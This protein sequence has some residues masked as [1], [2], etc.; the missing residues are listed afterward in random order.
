MDAGKADLVVSPQAAV[1][2]AMATGDDLNVVPETFRPAAEAR[3]SRNIAMA[4][5]AQPPSAWPV[6]PGR[7]SNDHLQGQQCLE[8]VLAGPSKPASVRPRS[9]THVS[10][11]PRPSVSVDSTSSMSSLGYKPGP[12]KHEYVQEDLEPGRPPRHLRTH[13]PLAASAFFDT[14]RFRGRMHGSTNSHETFDDPDLSRSSSDCDLGTG[15][16]LTDMNPVHDNNSVR[17]QVGW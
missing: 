13:P 17:N 12:P 7:Q 9:V 15:M 16:S 8:D 11:H 3:R 4:A 2:H 6:R 5:V 10:L 1:E 14:R